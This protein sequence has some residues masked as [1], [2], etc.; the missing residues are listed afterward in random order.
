MMEEAADAQRRSPWPWV[1]RS[2][3]RSR[4]R[5]CLPSTRRPDGSVGVIASVPDLICVL[6]DE[7]G[8][9]L[10]VPEFK[11]GYRVT[12]VGIACSPRWTET[13]AGLEIGGPSA[14]GYGDVEYRPLG[15][16]AKPRSVIEEFATPEAVAAVDDRVS[17]VAFG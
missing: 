4:T 10:G 17:Q 5:T 11:Y 6:D 1:A 16:Y 3:S 9:A 7:S 15:R 14:F 8:R 2:R 13:P 12:V